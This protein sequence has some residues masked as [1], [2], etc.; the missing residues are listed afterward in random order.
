MP[1]FSPLPL[2]IAVFFFDV[3]RP[4]GF[5]DSSLPPNDCRSGFAELSPPPPLNHDSQVP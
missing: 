4:E 5:P 2:Q 1:R 3:E